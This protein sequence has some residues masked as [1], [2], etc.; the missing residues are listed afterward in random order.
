MRYEEIEVR[1]EA[2]EIYNNEVERKIKVRVTQEKFRDILLK[3]DKKYIICNLDIESLLVVSHIK[4]WSNANAN[5]YEK[6]YKN[7]GLLLCANHDVLFDKGYIS[8]DDNGSIVISSKIDKANYDKLNIDINSNVVL[9]N[10]I[11]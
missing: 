9:K 8:F 6:Q 7:N 2:Y 11:S 3:R 1:E 5:D 10:E 4:P